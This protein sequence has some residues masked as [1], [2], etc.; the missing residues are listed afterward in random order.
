MSDKKTGGSV[1]STT[2]ENQT[3]MNGLGG[4]GM[5]MRD[6]FAGQA[7]AGDMADGSCGSYDND[8]DDR[9]LKERAEMLWRMADAMIATRYG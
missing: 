5:T 3:R 8:V 2:P 7:L 1:F 6:Y 4:D 9:H